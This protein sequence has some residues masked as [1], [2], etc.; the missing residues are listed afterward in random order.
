MVQLRACIG[1]VQFL[2]LAGGMLEIRDLVV[3][4]AG[5][6][7]YVRVLDG[8]DLAVREGEIW[9][10]VGE[11]GAGKSVLLR[12]ILGLLPRGWRV[13]RGTLRY[14]GA[15]LLAL[16][17][18]GLEALRGRVIGLMP[19]N[20]RQ[21]LNPLMTVGRQI[22]AVVRKHQAVAVT[23][24]VEQT[25]ALLRA[26]GIPDPELRYHAYPH[27]L[28][29]GM[30]QRIIIAMGLANAPTLILADE[31]TSG[32][33]VTISIQI[34]DLMREAV[35]EAGSALVLVSRDLG[36]VANYAQ[37]VGVMLGGQMI[38]QAGVIEFFD[39]ALH[40]YS[41][42]LIAAAAAARG[43]ERGSAADNAAIAGAPGPGCRSRRRCP[44]AIPAC[45]AGPVS[46]ACAGPQHF[47][48]CVRSEDLATVADDV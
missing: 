42:H 31:P 10:I 27:E 24:A 46:M 1:H 5:E 8:I 3:E 26:V 44:L 40:P 21:S 35:Q 22:A 15:D 14:N 13:V 30:C 29:G 33:N 18:R 9:G 17:E 37:H 39:R 2:V 7:G 20:A 28:S 19:S 38:E 43:A 4:Y 48:R 12:V 36:V 11:S 23:A 16:S 25:V 6:H 47:V 45:G 32:L 41:R 34:L